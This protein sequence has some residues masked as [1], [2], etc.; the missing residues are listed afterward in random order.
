MKLGVSYNVFDGEE[1]LESS[2]KSIRDNV[3]HISVVYQTIS[4]FG[5]ECGV[6][7][8]TLLED[9]KS[10]GLID[11][12]FK[13]KPLVNKG[14]HFNEMTKRN[15]GLSLSEGQKCT[16]HM[17]MDTDEFYTDKQFKYL[18]K[19]MVEG[20]YDSGA[21]Q[22]ITYYKEPIYRLEPKEEYYVS[23]IFKTQRGKSFIMGTPFPVLVDPTRRM[24]PGKCKVFTREEI[25]MHHMSYVRKDIKIKLTN[26]SASPNFKNINNIVTY[27]NNWKLPK[28]ALMGGAPDKFYDIVET[29]KL[30]DK[31]A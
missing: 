18:K 8:I 23:L 22:M 9:L 15:L 28:Q 27:Y 25:E 26:S 10:R 30:F 31:W 17:A 6:G 2:I 7:L 1:L 29:K 16:H 14:G 21:C 4:N 19:V 24:N 11:E 20:D 12:V 13:Y 5:N 3:D